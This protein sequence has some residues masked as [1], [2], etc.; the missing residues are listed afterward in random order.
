RRRF[1]DELVVQLSPRM[2]GVLGDYDRVLRQRSA[3][4]KSAGGLRRSRSRGPADPGGSGGSPD[5][6]TLDLWDAKLAA[7]GAQ[8]M[9][10]RMRLVHALA[11]HVG[12]SYEQLSTGQGEAVITYRSSLEAAAEGADRAGDPGRVPGAAPG[13]GPAVA[14]EADAGGPPAPALL[15]AR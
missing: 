11:P 14:E 1:L 6:R 3:L 4:L 15:E 9:A 8:I 2:A 7:A 13:G 5:L 10:A 12:W